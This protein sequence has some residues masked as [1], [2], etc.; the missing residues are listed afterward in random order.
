[1]AEIRFRDDIV[2]ED[3]ILKVLEHRLGWFQ[4]ASSSFFMDRWRHRRLV[5]PFGSSPHLGVGD[6]FN[7]SVS[8]FAPWASAYSATLVV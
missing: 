3:F 1:M 8:N 6:Y 4:L 7:P 2:N 5:R